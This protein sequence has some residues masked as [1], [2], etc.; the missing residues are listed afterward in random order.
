MMDS[1]LTEIIPTTLL[2]SFPVFAKQ[3]H[4]ELETRI[5][6]VAVNR[7]DL[8]LAVVIQP[9][10]VAVRCK[11]TSEAACLL[12]LWVRILLRAWMF[13]LCVCCP[14]CSR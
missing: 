4:D 10:P 9:T 5:F 13:F 8:F 1:T 6:D 14:L 3:P 12:G 11:A 7:A 2:R